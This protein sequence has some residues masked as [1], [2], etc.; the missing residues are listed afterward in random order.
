MDPAKPGGLPDQSAPA[1]KETDL[2]TYAGIATFFRAPFR[3]DWRQIDLALVGLPSDAGVTQRPGTRHGPREVRNQ[4]CCVLPFNPLTRVAPFELARVADVGD[5]PIASPFNLERVVADIHAFYQRLRQAGVVPITAGGDHSITYPILKAL[6]AVRPV[7]LVHIDAHLDTATQ[8]AG[9]TVQ[10]CSPFYNAVRDGVLDPRRT[11]SI[12]IRDSYSPFQS[13]SQESGMTV[14]D[15]D[16]FYELGVK[17]TLAEARRVVGDGPVY[18]TFDIDSLDP[19][20]APGTG[21]PVVGGLTSYEGKK[22]VQGLRG[23]DVIGAD[24]V[25]VSPPFDTGGITALAGAQ[26]MFELFCVAAEAFTRR[27]LG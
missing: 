27:S 18:V 3:D 20:F 26:M 6:G 23:L 12:G 7:G 14:I 2:K 8:V 25:E 24:V 10:H 9:S 19:A 4:S 1:G 16:R 22:L 17:G 15:I 13:F 21:V 5:V 11:V